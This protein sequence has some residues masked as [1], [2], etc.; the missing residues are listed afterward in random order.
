MIPDGRIL[1]DTQTFFM[2]NESQEEKLRIGM[3]PGKTPYAGRDK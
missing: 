3:S 1:P 2:D